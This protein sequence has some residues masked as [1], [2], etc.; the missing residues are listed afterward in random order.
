MGTWI[1]I[2]EVE[3]IP[4]MGARKVVIA[5]EEIA[6]FKTRDELIFAVKNECPHKKGQLSEGLVH[7]HIIT[8]PLHNLDINLE[9]GVALE[10][11]AGCVKPYETKIEE[12]MVY[13]QF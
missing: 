9:N 6:L 8:C 7:E 11:G 3:N 5:N 13:I 10:E 12:G 4:S 2:I 1:K